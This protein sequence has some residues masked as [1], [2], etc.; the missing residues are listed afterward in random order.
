MTEVNLNIDTWDLIDSLVR[1]MDNEELFDFIIEI[2]STMLDWEFTE[3]LYQ[4]FKEEH[5][6]WKAEKKA[7]LG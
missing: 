7:G 3:A 1:N 6:T 5:K 2:D 4:Y